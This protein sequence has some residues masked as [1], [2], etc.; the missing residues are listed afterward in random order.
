MASRSQFLRAIQKKVPGLRIDP[1]ADETVFRCPKCKHPRFYFNLRKGVGFCQRGSCHWAPTARSL[2]KFW[3]LSIDLIPAFSE[4]PVSEPSSTVELLSGAHQLLLKREGE[5][6]SHCIR[7]QQD[8]QRLFE[9]RH[10][11]YEAQYRFK[12]HANSSRIIVPVYETKIDRPEL[13]FYVA[14]LKFW[15]EDFWTSQGALKYKYPE[16]A[17]KGDHLFHWDALKVRKNIVLVENTFNAIWLRDFGA[18][19]SF[20]SQLS[21]KQIE[22][23]SRSRVENV[24]ILWDEDAKKSADT[25][26]KALRSAG[27]NAQAAIL[28]DEP[29]AHS[30]AQLEGIIGQTFDRIRDPWAVLP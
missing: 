17:K 29:E 2:F 28:S 20:G 19:T 15:D 9:A 16:D 4:A 14:R 6:V 22:L 7:C 25:A 18:T 26:A 21:R 30:L 8:A 24:C 27:V 3:G 13:V 1:A 11:P 10:I 23:I 12:I 5:L